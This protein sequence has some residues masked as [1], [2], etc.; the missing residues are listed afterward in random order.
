MNLKKCEIQCSKPYSI[1]IGSGLL[2]SPLL[3]DVCHSLK[4]RLAIISDARL[5][6]TIA[7]SL[8]QS[9]TTSGMN[10]E[11]FTMPSGEI[12]K[13]RETKQELE[14]AL[15]EKKY[16]RDSCFIALGGGVTT[17][18]VGY[19]ASTYCRGVP[20]ITIPTTLLAMVDASIGG[21]TGVNTPHGKNIIG[22]F[23]QPAAVLIDVDV[24]KTLPKK[25]W[26]NGMVEIIKH[27]LI[28]DAPL[29]SLL[30]T[31]TASLYNHTDLL[32]NVIDQ[33]CCIKKN[34]VEQDELESGLRERLNFG[35]TIGH[36]LEQIENYQISH[37]EAV[38]IGI[39]VEA[40]LSLRSGLLKAE[41]FDAIESLL[42][43]YQLPLR[44]T[45]FKNK[46]R[47]LEQLMMDKKSKFGKA[48]FVLLNDIGHAYRKGNK[49]SFPIDPH[50]LNSTLDWASK[51][52][53]T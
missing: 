33:S 35:H 28:A 48:H 17:D 27:S 20:T 16:G 7:V 5:A 30:T 22:T 4:R 43:A 9:L 51:H 37:G 12:Y 52:F 31:S 34:I 25:E 19:L 1:Y 49:A 26:N 32:L 39:L 36:A 11:I 44:T 15:L 29:F 14:D 21:K 8:Q 38:A 10:V 47:F 13:T 45:A 40:Q 23:H 50:L 24:L 2:Q 46:T 41:A 18:L 42:R 3:Q 6:D 53:G